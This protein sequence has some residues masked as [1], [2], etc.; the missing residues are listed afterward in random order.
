MDRRLRRQ[1][2]ERLT[3]DAGRIAS[4]FAVRFRSI[5]AEH[6]NVRRRYGICYDDG[7]IRIRL[8]HAVTGEPLRYSSLVNTLCHE[9]AH[10]R[11]FDH[12]ARFQALY[13]RMLGWARR[14]GIYRPARA[15]AT[16]TTADLA[17]GG[18]KS[19]G[20][21]NDVGSSPAGKREAP[22]QLELFG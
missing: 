20:G 18:A 4:Q 22:R 19:G 11:Y 1:L 2:V 5:E 8:A 7:S 15:H 17:P 12:S 16:L 13:S 3:S 6:G 14:E 21:E 9:L 10:L